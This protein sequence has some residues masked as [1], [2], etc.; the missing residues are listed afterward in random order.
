M[1]V[2]LGEALRKETVLVVAFGMA[3]ISDRENSIL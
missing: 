2:V 3:F 1:N